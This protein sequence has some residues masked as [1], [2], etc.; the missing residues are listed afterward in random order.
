[1]PAQRLNK[2]LGRLRKVSK[3]SR[4]FSKYR[5]GMSMSRS[6]ITVGSSSGRMSDHSIVPDKQYVKVSSSYAGTVTLAAGANFAAPFAVYANSLYQPF[7]TAA[8]VTTTGGFTNTNGSAITQ[9]PIGYQ[10]YSA[11]YNYYRVRSS[12]IKVTLVPNVA[13]GTSGE[14]VQ[15][16]VY[17][18]TFSA[19][20]G[21]TTFNV[22]T[23]QRYSK[24]K[25]ITS[26]QDTDK[27]TVDNYLTSHKALGMSKEQY[28]D[29]SPIA[30]GSAP[31]GGTDW[32][33]IV[34]PSSPAG[35]TSQTFQLYIQLEQYVELTDPAV[36]TA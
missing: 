18:S 31:A 15:C 4:D 20:T 30:F 25:P 29:Q 28:D 1:M 10:S 27:N 5:Q 11:L 26:Y 35:V 36:Q 23:N 17:P 9:N 21:V 22:N 7:N 2:K 3:K 34:Q 19:G 24:W 13:V 8:A 6:R 14:T 12:R 33:W 32:F 16:T